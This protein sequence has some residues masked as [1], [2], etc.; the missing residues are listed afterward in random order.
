M[1]EPPT[2]PIGARMAFDAFE[3]DPDD[4]D[5]TISLS[6]PSS[7]VITPEPAVLQLQGH[8]PSVSIGVA[9]LTA[10][11][12]KVEAQGFVSRP[13]EPVDLLWSPIARM[14]MSPTHYRTSWVQHISDMNFERHECLK[15]NDKWGGRWAVVRA[16]YYSVPRWVWR[17]LAA[18]LLVPLLHWWSKFR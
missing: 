8:A 3:D 9:S 6:L 12:P 10:G 5:L 4:E 7:V 1:N 17:L 11:P 16:H 14:L 15:R 18:P 2:M 13:E